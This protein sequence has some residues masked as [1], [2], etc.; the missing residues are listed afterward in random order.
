MLID[1]LSRYLLLSLAHP[2][3]HSVRLSMAP[4]VHGQRASLN[5][6]VLLRVRSHLLP[7]RQRYVHLYGTIWT[8][9][10]SRDIG[11]ARR[12]RR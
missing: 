12:S 2:L 1:I 6:G 11:G 9:F 8:R 7:R 3:V 10:L 5:H 4:F